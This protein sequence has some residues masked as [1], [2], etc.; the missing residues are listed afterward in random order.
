VKTLDLP[1][2]PAPGW[3]LSTVYAAVLD[4]SDKSFR[5]LRR[6]LKLPGRTLG[7]A[8]LLHSVQVVRALPED[9]GVEPAPPK[10]RR[11]TRGRRR[12]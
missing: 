6:R 9:F 11:P 8:L 1:D 12:P 7:L 10:K 3:H 2:W 4:I 5:D